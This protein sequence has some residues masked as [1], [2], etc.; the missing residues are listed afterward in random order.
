MYSLSIFPPE[1]VEVQTVGPMWIL[2]C[3][4]SP[5][6]PSEEIAHI[7]VSIVKHHSSW[8]RSTAWIAFVQIWAVGIVT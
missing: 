5:I 6:L 1:P 7:G 3:T 4:W 8:F 2:F